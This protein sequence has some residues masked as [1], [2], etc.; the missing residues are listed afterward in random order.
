MV[1]M[2]GWF[3]VVKVYA[4][5]AFRGSPDVRQA[6]SLPAKLKVYYGSTHQLMDFIYLFYPSLFIS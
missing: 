6:A 5:R 3:L 2:L 1:Y 4:R